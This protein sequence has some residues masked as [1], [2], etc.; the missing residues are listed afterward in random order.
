LIAD[1]RSPTTP[2]PTARG[3]G[4]PAVAAF[5]Q[6]LDLDAPLGA[7]PDFLTWLASHAP[8]RLAEAAGTL[9]QGAPVEWRR[10]MDEHLSSPG[11]DGDEPSAV[12]FVVASVVQP[13]AE[14]AA[15]S[16]ETPWRPASAGPP[17]PICDSP[18]VVG[19]LRQEG[20]GARRSLI[21]S[22]CL[23]EHDYMRVVCPAC[24]ERKFEAL[25]IFTAD[26]FPHVRI[27]ACDSC[28]TYLKSV[29]LTKD[30]H[31]VPIVDDI[32]SVSLDVWARDR[33]YVRLRR[34]LLGL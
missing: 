14:R 18:P 16:P 2:G 28:R 21:C 22:L 8:A 20:H 19:V 10:A 7:I 23:T 6:A 34:N 33:G 32:A 9:Q 15:T 13:F 29:D 25:P 5:R 31:A 4:R 30:G 12:T 11:D 17:C 26:Q 3:S 1:R 27:E 24:G